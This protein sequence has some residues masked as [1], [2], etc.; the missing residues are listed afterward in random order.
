M[1]QEQ[2]LPVPPDPYSKGQSGT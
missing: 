2:Y 1:H